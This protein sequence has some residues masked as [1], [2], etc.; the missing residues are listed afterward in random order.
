MNNH[1]NSLV[2]KEE[3]QR[4]GIGRTLLEHAIRHLWNDEIRS[5][6]L[7][8]LATTTAAVRVYESVGFVCYDELWL[9]QRLNAQ[10]L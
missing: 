1:I 3:Q 5:V 2:V 4:R 6:S 10:R 7:N 9:Y 8:V